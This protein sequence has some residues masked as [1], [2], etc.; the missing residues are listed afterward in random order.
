M[1]D[2]NAKVGSSKNKNRYNSVGNFNTGNTSN[3]NGKHY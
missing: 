2:F 3:C 1:G